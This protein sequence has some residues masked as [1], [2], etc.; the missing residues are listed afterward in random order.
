MSVCVCVRS[1]DFSSTDIVDQSI[2][3]KRENFSKMIKSER[4]STFYFFSL[5]F[6]LSLSLSSILAFFSLFCLSASNTDLRMSDINKHTHTSIYSPFHLIFFLLGQNCQEEK[7]S[8][9]KKIFCKFERECIP[10]FI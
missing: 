1:F 7:Y 5:F 6:S 3:N 8:R 4:T 9:K 10:S 2:E